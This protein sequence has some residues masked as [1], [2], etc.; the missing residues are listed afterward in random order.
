MIP[1]YQFYLLY[2]SRPGQSS[3]RK[4]NY[5]TPGSFSSGRRPMLFRLIYLSEKGHAQN[6]QGFELRVAFTSKGTFLI[7]CRR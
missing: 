1:I 6:I 2:S 7:V 4:Q 3:W 5:K